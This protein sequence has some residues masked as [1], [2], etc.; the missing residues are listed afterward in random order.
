MWGKKNKEIE[1]K[2]L[3]K[4]TINS[5]NKQIETLEEQKKVFIDKAKEAKKPLL[6]EFPR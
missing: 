6:E 1:K 5:M 2:M 3:I 4:K